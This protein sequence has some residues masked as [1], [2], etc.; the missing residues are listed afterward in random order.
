MTDRTVFLSIAAQWDNLGD[1]E[2]RHVLVDWLRDAGLP[3]RVFAGTMPDGYVDAFGLPAEMI[4]RS[5]TAFQ[6]DLWRAV[7]TRRASIVFSPGPQGFGPLGK[8]P[9]TLVNLINVRLV[10]ASGGGAVA[11]G[12]SLRGH[13]ALARAIEQMLVNAFDLYVVRDIGSDDALGQPLRRAPDLAFFRAPGT[14]LPDITM[15]RTQVA[16]SF[17]SDRAVDEARVGDAVAFVRARGFSPVFVTQV[18][19]DDARHVTLARRFGADLVEWG[20]RSHLAQIARL[21]VCYARTHAV[22]SNRLHGLLMGVGQ[23]AVPVALEDGTA[24]KLPSTIEPWLKLRRMPTAALDL[25]TPAMA[26]LW[27][28][29]EEAQRQLVM[30]AGAAHTALDT[31]RIDMLARLRCRSG[32]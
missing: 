8:L 1:I 4:E 28:S 5:S 6:R 14:P 20:D 10:R 3:L 19:R 32:S 11:V 7:A 27:D 21:R 23:G 31:V 29:P 12:R 25:A 13:G 26:S 24:N 17:R 22:I 2:I 30:E 15:P 18:L 16:F 9:K